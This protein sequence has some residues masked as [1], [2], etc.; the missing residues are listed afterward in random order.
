M[1]TLKATDQ[2][3]NNVNKQDIER[4][5]A[6]GRSEAGR[7]DYELYLKETARVML[8]GN[9]DISD[10][11]INGQTGAVVKIYVNPNTQTPSIIFIKFDDDKAGQNMINNSNNQYAKE[12]KVAPVEPILA[13]IKIK[14]NKPLSPEIQ[15][16]QFPITLAWACTVHKVQATSKVL[17]KG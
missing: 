6:R 7:L 4:V 8:T 1:F 2:Y 15:R 16:I 11:L 13:K 17:L 5:L 9:I 14:P 12:H 10:R 3:P